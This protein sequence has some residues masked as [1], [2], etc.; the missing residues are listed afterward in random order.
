[1]FNYNHLFYFWMV[2]REGSIAGAARVTGVTPPNV[3]AQVAR[4]EATLGAKLFEKSGRGLVLTPLGAAMYTYVDE[5]FAIAAEMKKMLE[6]GGRRTLRLAVGVTDGVPAVVTHRLLAPILAQPRL[7]QL[8]VHHGPLARLTAELGARELDVVLCCER[9][10]A[11]SPVRARPHLLGK[12]SLV[13]LAAEELARSVAPGFPRSL[14][15]VPF[16][17]PP[18]SAILRR[19]FDRWIQA[20]GAVPAIVAETDDWAGALLMAQSGAGVVA[21]PAVTEDEVRRRYAL[22]PVGRAHDA[23]QHFYAFTAERRPRH[24]PVVAILDAARADP[25]R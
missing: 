7:A 8:V 4:L 25:I 17:L 12:S 21:V 20:Q 15:G 9:L 18:P 10:P 2:A 14:D 1:M 16:V 23:V 22:E 6:N 11:G 19:V 3:S 13:L 24:P 5:M